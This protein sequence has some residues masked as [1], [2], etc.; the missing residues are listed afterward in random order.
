[1]KSLEDLK[2]EPDSSRAVVELVVEVE[3]GA[4]GADCTIEQ[5]VAQATRE[6]AQKVAVRLQ[7]DRSIRVLGAKAVRVV[8][9]ARKT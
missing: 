4:W 6:A 9:P 5:A 3:C 1:M 8:C 2:M 7:E